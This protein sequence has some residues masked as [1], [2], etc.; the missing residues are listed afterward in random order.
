MADFGLTHYNIVV[1]AAVQP[2]GQ[3]TAKT[4]PTQSHAPMFMNVWHTASSGHWPLIARMIC[5]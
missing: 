1:Q 3:R 4:D 2:K 5:A